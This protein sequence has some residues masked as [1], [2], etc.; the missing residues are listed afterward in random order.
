MHKV[1]DKCVIVQVGAVKIYVGLA[2]AVEMLRKQDET[3][4]FFHG[5]NFFNLS[6][7]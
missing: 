6:N 1:R 4:E 7:N 5:H 3:L 2:A